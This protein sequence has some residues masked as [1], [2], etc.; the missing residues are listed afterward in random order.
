MTMIKLLDGSE[1]HFDRPFKPNIRIIAHALAHLNRWTGHTRYPFSVAQHS[2]M[3]SYMVP[4]HYALEALLHDATEAYL[5]DVSKPLKE[6]LP[7]FKVLEQR[8]WECIADTFD[9][10]YKL[11]PEVTYA[12]YQALALEDHMLRGGTHEWNVEYDVSIW[13]RVPPYDQ[14]AEAFLARFKELTK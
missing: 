5:G 3:V 2:V 6:L 1:H 11:S 4:K 8:H 7:Q 14:A 13:A 9:L 10:P 12:D